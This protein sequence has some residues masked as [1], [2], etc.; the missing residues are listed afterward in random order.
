MVKDRTTRFT[1]EWGYCWHILDV[2]NFSE[3]K[4]HKGNTIKHTDGCLLPNMYA[5]FERNLYF[6]VNSKVAY[7][8]MMQIL[9]DNDEHFID[10][11]R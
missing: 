8:T 3:I 6:G 1:Y 2:P 7:N 11:I 4:I 9:K 10:I 5:G